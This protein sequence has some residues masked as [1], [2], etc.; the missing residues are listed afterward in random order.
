MDLQDVTVY[1]C[2]MRFNKVLTFSMKRKKKKNKRMKFGLHCICGL[3]IDSAVVHCMTQNER[4]I[5]K[6]RTGK[7]TE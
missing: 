2:N 6:R 3:F 5:N 7:D 4:D 1:D